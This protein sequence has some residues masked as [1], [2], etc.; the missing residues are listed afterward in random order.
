MVELTFEGQTISHRVG[1]YMI[2]LT[3]VR[4]GAY[5]IEVCHVTGAGAG[6][7]IYEKSFGSEDLARQ[8]ARRL[9]EICK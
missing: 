7:R 8:G 5:F 3:W 1:R 4:E 6:Y 2:H 9:V